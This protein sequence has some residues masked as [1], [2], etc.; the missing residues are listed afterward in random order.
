G[1]DAVGIFEIGSVYFPALGAGA[2]APR[3]AVTARPSTGEIADIAAAIPSQPRHLA[4]VLCGP[5][6]R[7]GW[8]GPGRTADWSDAIG[9]AVRII[10]D[11]GVT[12]D[13]SAGLDAPF[14]PGRTAA[15]SVAGAVVGSAGEL[16]P[17]V[18]AAWGLPPRTV[19][20]EFDLDA[21]TALA[22]DLTVTA[23]TLRIMPVAKEDVALVVTADTPAAAVAQ[24]LR[25]GGGDLLESVR[26]F[27]VYTGAQ[28]GE[29]N[30]SLAFSLRFRAGDRTLAVEEVTAARNAAVTRAAEATGAVLRGP[31]GS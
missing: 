24:A 15:L 6:E 19:A 1:A 21:V 12:A 28:V 27:D 31:S 22:A 26:L 10:G 17:R 16:H 20:F 11:V 14:H 25:E 4:A 23:P 8:W 7:P 13:V 30:K 9:L 3:L 29:G 18:C 2:V 5:W